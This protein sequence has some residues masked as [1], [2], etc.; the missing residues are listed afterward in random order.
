MKT[1]LSSTLMMIAMVTML[2]GASLFAEELTKPS[3]IDPI[4]S[5]EL[6]ESFKVGLSR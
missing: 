4:K 2:M 3:K 5:I 6:S 1:I